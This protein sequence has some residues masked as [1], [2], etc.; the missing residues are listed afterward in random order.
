MIG[1]YLFRDLWLVERGIGHWGPEGGNGRDLKVLRCN[2]PVGCVVHLQ[3]HRVIG[4]LQQTQKPFS[5]GNIYKCLLRC[6]KALFPGLVIKKYTNF[7]KTLSRAVSATTRGSQPLVVISKGSLELATAY[8]S[9]PWQ[10]FLK[11]VYLLM[12][13]PGKKIGTTEFLHIRAIF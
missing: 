3:L 5:R 2:E 4:D 9:Q 13:R 1:R 12:T 7:Q 8:G 11:A 6:G 10:G